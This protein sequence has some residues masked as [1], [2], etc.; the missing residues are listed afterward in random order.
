MKFGTVPTFD[1]VGAVLAH[2]LRAT[3]V[4][5]GEIYRI[6]KGTKL[7]AGH[8]ADL[9]G[10]GQAEVVVARYEIGDVE[11]NAAAAGLAEA[12]AQD[13]DALGLRMSKAGA[14]RVNL[15]AQYAGV[16]VI[17]EAAIL[18]INAVN[19]MITIATVPQYHRTDA[20]SMVATIKIISYAVP[21][22]FL[23]QAQKAGV[24]ALRVA[25]PH[26]KTATLIETYVGGQEPSR[27]GREAMRARLERFGV[28]LSPRILVAHQEGAITQ[29]LSQA[30]G[31][32]VFLLTASATSD[33]LDVGPQAL[34]Q[35]GGQ[36]TGFGMPVDPGNLL[37]FG[38]LG[39]KPIIGLP[40]CAR[41]PA[42]NG[43]D[44]VLERLICGISL[45]QADIAAMGVGGLLKE[46]PT[47]P[48]LRA[49]TT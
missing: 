1:A 5:T 42:L 26:Y 15:Y 36:V 45:S 8:T 43:A 7:T 9:V 13:A 41:S 44:W 12:V 17:D 19:P 33:P 11:E 20:Q 39:S 40:G 38:E 23:L 10:T 28:V 18:A 46:I 34:R 47:R 48:R 16:V 29:A 35:A 37:F 27:K 24:G 4:Q 31:A 25:G 49:D 32:M 6:A 3:S 14:G 30:Q 21:E 22:Q 2:S